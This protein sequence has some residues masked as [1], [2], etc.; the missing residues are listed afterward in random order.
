MSRSQDGSLV[1][2]LAEN[3]FE[4]RTLAY[5]EDLENKVSALTA[6]QIIEAMRRHIDPQQLSYFKAGDFK[7]AA[8]A[9]P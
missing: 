7:K 8:A 5:Q 9:M 6:Q 3:E 2:I 4:G 1:G